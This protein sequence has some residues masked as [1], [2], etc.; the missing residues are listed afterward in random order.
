[1]AVIAWRC[2][3]AVQTMAYQPPAWAHI[4]QATGRDNGAPDAPL[5]A[6]PVKPLPPL[7]ADGSAIGY[8]AGWNMTANPL[9]VSPTMETTI[10]A[11]PIMGFTIDEP[12]VSMA[13]ILEGRPRD[14][15]FVGVASGFLV[16]REAGSYGI[17]PR[18]ERRAGPVA[19]CMVR[20]AVNGHRIT[21]DLELTVAQ[22]VMR[23]F[24]P[25][26]FAFQPGLY[27]I[28]WAFGCWHGS[29]MSDLG[30]ISVMLIEP[31]G[32]AAR[33]LQATDIVR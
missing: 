24:A 7:R 31:G 13:L 15:L 25:A 30:R 21:S 14:H 23:D 33:P 18:F 12:A 1:L 10:S 4:T 8:D 9:T 16:I 27:R 6:S 29:D 28:E 19:D 32:A 3:V 22:R 5:P 26:W 17:F 2:T 20:L 11:T